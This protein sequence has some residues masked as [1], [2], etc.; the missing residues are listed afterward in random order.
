MNGNRHAPPRALCRAILHRHHFVHN[1]RRVLPSLPGPPTLYSLVENPTP[2]TPL[3]NPNRNP[4]QTCNLS[5][6]HRAPPPQRHHAGAARAFVIWAQNPIPSP[7]FPVTKRQEYPWARPPSS[8]ARD[9]RGA[10]Q[11]S[12]VV[13]R[14]EGFEV[15]CGDRDGGERVGVVGEGEGNE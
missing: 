14:A 13:S 8:P 4:L 2:L 5:Y 10:G 15:C 11:C 12:A 9:G 7:P 6:L 1:T 3:R